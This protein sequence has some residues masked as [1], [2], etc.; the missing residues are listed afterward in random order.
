MNNVVLRLSNVK[1]TY[2]SGDEG[3]LPVLQGVDF[4]L[5]AGELVALVAPSGT[6]KSTLLHLAGLLDTPDE[7][8]IEIAGQNTRGLAD[9]GRTALRRDQIGFVYQFHHLLAEFTAQENVMLPQMIAGVRKAE[10][11]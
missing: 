5:H 10:A 7:G 6:G 1:K 3:S 9:A 4:T 11:R 8:D 2:R